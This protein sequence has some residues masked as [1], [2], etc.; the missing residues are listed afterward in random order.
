MPAAADLSLE[1]LRV[2]CREKDEAIKRKEKKLDLL[3]KAGSGEALREAE[4][5]MKRIGSDLR[6]A[7]VS[8][9]E[10]IKKTL[11]AE[12]VPLAQKKDQLTKEIEAF[13]KEHEEQEARIAQLDADVHEATRGFETF[14]TEKRE[15]CETVICLIK[16]MQATLS[17]KMEEEGA[18]EQ[19]PANQPYILLQAIAELTKDREGE[20][21]NNER[22]LREMCQIIKMKKKRE[23]ELQV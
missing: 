4:T 3:R 10:E 12:G 17:S 11:S 15:L 9:E 2:L 20:V 6:K 7:K 1:E 14:R 8:A 13:E 19:K 21:S 16:D 5:R 23:E 22:Q 18:V